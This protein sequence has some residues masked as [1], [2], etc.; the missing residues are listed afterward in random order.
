MIP[1]NKFYIGQ[2]ITPLAF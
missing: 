2:I 1:I